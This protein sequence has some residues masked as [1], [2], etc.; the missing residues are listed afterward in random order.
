MHVAPFIEL[1][2]SRSALC[3]L[4]ERLMLVRGRIGS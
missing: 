1:L 3:L 2:L 4:P